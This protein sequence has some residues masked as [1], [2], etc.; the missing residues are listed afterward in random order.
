MTRNLQNSAS[1]C[2]H[3]LAV[4]D[5][6]YQF[7]MYTGTAKDDNQFDKEIGVVGKVVDRLRSSLP[8]YMPFKIYADNFFTTIPLVKKSHVLVEKKDFITGQFH[9]RP[10]I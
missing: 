8:D 9:G 10:K 3:E 7:E 1:K 5:M 2:R 6:I 4:Q